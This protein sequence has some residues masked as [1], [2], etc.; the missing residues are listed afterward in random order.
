MDAM[1]KLVELVLAALQFQA[2]GLLTIADMFFAR[3]TLVYYRLG[4]TISESAAIP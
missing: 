3:A 4:R 2:E 1:A